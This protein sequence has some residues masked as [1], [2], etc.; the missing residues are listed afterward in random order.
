VK[1]RERANDDE[2]LLVAVTGSDDKPV[3]R[4]EVTVPDR[5]SLRVGYVPQGWIAKVDG[6]QITASG[7]SAAR[8]HLRLDAS[9]REQ[10]LKKLS[11]KRCR[12]R[13]WRDDELL[14]GIEN[15]ILPDYKV[16][17]QWTLDDAMTLPP[18]VSIGDPFVA[19]PTPNFRNGEWKLIVADTAS[20]LAVPEHWKLNA[21][22][23]QGWV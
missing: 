9:P 23:V 17:T 5:F 7:P 3:T 10:I 2:S 15:A 16:G 4:L 11:G 22:H 18:V 12:M 20:D 13:A 14:F 21:G 6:K 1:V 19:T 8:V